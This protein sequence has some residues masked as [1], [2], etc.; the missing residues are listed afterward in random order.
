MKMKTSL[1]LISLF[2]LITVKGQGVGIGTNTPNS[3][4]ILDVNSTNK[5]I[6]LP[7]VPDTSNISNPSAGLFM[8]NQNTR[9]P[10]FHDGTRWQS[11]NSFASPRTDSISY[12]IASVTGDFSVGIFGLTDISHSG[13]Y[14]T[15]VSMNT[16]IITKGYDINSEAFK[17]GLAAQQTFPVIE[18]KLYNAGDVNPYF[19]VKLTTWHII[20]E[21]MN[22]SP[23]DG[24]LTEQY[25]L[26][27]SLI[28]FKDWV[29]NKFFTY[30]PGTNLVSSTY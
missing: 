11:L 1:F 29:N 22:Y 30:N 17:R 6:L 16:I 10:N 14:T 8:F 28:G 3:N 15:A 20:T 25:T 12:S 21:S 5:G 7:R 2:A 18:F 4:A 26:T 19:S 27:A 23:A 24:K 13:T 9:T